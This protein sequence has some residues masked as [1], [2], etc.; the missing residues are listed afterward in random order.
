MARPI[1]VEYPGAVYHVMARGNR[2]EA[3]FRDEED[4]RCFLD[5]LTKA[6]EKTGWRIHSCVLMGNH[7]HLLVETAEGN[8]VA[9]MKWLPGAYTQRY[10]GRHKVF[11][12]LFQGRYQAVIVAGQE[13]MYFPVVRTYIHLNPARAKLIRVGEEHLERAVKGR[14]GESHSGAAKRAHGEAGAEREL[15]VG[16]EGAGV[17]WERDCGSAKRGG[18]ESGAGVVVESAY[19]GDAQMGE[20]ASEDGALHA[21][22]SG[23]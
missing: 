7:Y 16:F 18:R 22:N 5:T 21:S 3:I 20:R 12:H 19:G 11:G 14:Q 17:G 9:G 15:A 10:N 1:R 8:L 13:A 6:S 2:G 4:R 23:H